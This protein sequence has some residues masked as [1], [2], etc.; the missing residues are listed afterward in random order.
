[1]KVI[2][3]LLV[4][5]TLFAM[6]GCSTRLTA[7]MAP[8]KTLNSDLGNIY[9]EHFS[10]DKRNLNYIIADKLTLLGYPATPLNS[11]DTPD[12]AN[13]IITYIDN[14]QWDITN[15]LIKIKINFRDAESKQLVITGES[16]RTSLARKPPEFMIQEALEKMLQEAGL[17]YNHLN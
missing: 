14:W 7:T 12:K 13:M 8:G 9:V 4:L 3:Y 10:P 17:P 16:F 2:K 6:A 15:Y 5:G 1:M 11:N